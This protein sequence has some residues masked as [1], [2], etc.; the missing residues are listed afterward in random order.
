MHGT[1]GLCLQVAIARLT[2]AGRFA[3]WVTRAPYAGGYVHHDLEWPSELT[4]CWLAW[5]ELFA[6]HEPHQNLPGAA[7]LA[8]IHLDLGEPNFSGN[9][10]M[11]ELGVQLWNWLFS[12]PVAQTLAHSQGLAIGQNDCL[13]L[14]LECRDA[15]LIPL[16]WEIMQPELGKSPIT[17]SQRLFFSRTTSAVDSLKLSAASEYLRILLVLGEPD[18]PGQKCLALKQEA[19]ALQQ[20]VKNGIQ[21]SVRDPLTPNLSFK[22][23]TLVQP[24]IQELVTTLQSES[25][26]LFLYSGHGAPGPDGG[27]IYL[28]PGV[29]LSGTELAQALVRTGVILAVFNTCWS[30]QLSLG[31]EALHRS[32]LTEVLLHHGLPAV[33]G[34]RDSIADPEALSFIQSFMQAVASRKSVEE[35]T[36]IARQELLTLFKFNQ[37]AW[38]LPILYVHP[39]FS[40]SVIA[41]LADEP[42]EEL[43]FIPTNL[44]P[45]R[46]PNARVR[47]I[48]DPELVTPVNGGLLRVGRHPDNDLVVGER[49]VSQHHGEIFCRETVASDGQGYRYFFRDFSRFGTCVYVEDSWQKIHH[50]ELPL[51]MGTRLRFG[52]EIGPTL[53]FL[54]DVEDRSTTT[55]C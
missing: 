41:P 4:Q 36:A 47:F 23:T 27:Y 33:L 14:R 54:L 17:T 28:A 16:P 45:R 30:A 18:T 5:Q 38:T 26:N 31:Q 32:S 46:F 49:W 37:P 2:E 52:S 39:E 19:D 22:V 15:N 35:A 48:E 21:Q 34:M 24:T 3:V 6:L 53:E 51:R 9:R 1:P 8:K 44:N 42:L 40:G 43:T 12:G 11:Q 7:Q 55:P 10:L 13:R 25:Y 20:A 50:A 29:T